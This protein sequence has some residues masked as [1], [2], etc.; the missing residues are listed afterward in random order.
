MNK[1]LHRGETLDWIAGRVTRRGPT[2]AFDPQVY[3]A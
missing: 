1:L 3:V 2:A